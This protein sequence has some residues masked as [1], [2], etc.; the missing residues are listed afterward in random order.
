VESLALTRPLAECRVYEPKEQVTLD[1]DLLPVFLILS[2]RDQ[3][4]GSKQ[5]QRIKT[6]RRLTN[7]SRVITDVGTHAMRSCAKN[8]R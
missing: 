7:G 3:L 4:S 8:G 2:L 1:A 5:S 6:R